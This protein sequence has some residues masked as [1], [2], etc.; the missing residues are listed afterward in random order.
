MT[1]IPEYTDFIHAFA[2][3][4]VLQYFWNERWNDWERSYCP[5]FSDHEWRVKPAEPKK[6]VIAT[7]IYKDGDVQTALH[8]SQRFLCLVSEGWKHVMPLDRE[9]TLP[10]E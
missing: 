5:E 9:V 2:D 7:L 1:N 6:A 10:E 3:G 8:E 4:K